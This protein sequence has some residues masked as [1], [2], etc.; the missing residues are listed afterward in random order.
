MN[1]PPFLSLAAGLSSGYAYES[2]PVIDTGIRHRYARQ[3]R[4]SSGSRSAM[5][6][7]DLRQNCRTVHV[8]IVNRGKVWVE[9][10]EL[11]DGPRLMQSHGP[12]RSLALAEAKHDRLVSAMLGNDRY[13]AVVATT[14]RDESD[15]IDLSDIK[16]DF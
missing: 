15:A 9:E 6:P 13:G 10:W 4:F 5:P 11:L 16:G 2:V 14:R 1:I 3:A 8:R 7:P 12:Y